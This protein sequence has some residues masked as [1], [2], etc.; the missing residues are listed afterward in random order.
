MWLVKISY[1][2]CFIY[3]IQKQVEA[4]TVHLRLRFFLKANLQVIPVIRLHCWV[5]VSPFHGVSVYWEAQVLIECFF[6]PNPCQKINFPA[7]KLR[8]NTGAQNTHAPF[9][10]F[11]GDVNKINLFVFSFFLRHF[12]C[13][14]EVNKHCNVHF[15]FLYFHSWNKIT[16]II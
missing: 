7:K 5:K 10:F 9:C 13:W 16:W 15:L 8:K 2:K 12:Y 14:I 1:F 6:H 11:L 4:F 3:S